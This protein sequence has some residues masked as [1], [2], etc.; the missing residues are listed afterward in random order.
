MSDTLSFFYSP[1]VGRVKSRPNGAKNS[2][3]G[4]FHTSIEYQTPIIV[5]SPGQKLCSEKFFMELSSSDTCRRDGWRGL[6]PNPLINDRFVQQ[7]RK[8]IKVYTSF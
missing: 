5:D 6:L 1:D 8:S 3:I 7:N 2:G 4:I